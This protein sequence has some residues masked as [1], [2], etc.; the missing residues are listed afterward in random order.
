ME[1]LK[2]SE[3]LKRNKDLQ[4]SFAGTPIEIAVLSNIIV[5]QLKDILEFKLRS[6][7]INVTAN[8]G[9][10]D[11]ILQDCDRFKQSK[12]IIIFWEASNIL[13][14]FH[15]KVEN[16]DQETYL[17]YL[18]KVKEELSFVFNKL[19]KTSL[20]LFN[21]FTS[22]A[23][24]NDFLQESKLSQFCDDLNQFVQ[25]QKKSN[26]QVVDI[27]RIFFDISLKESL[28]LRYYNSS[29]ALYTIRFFKEYSRL[30]HYYLQHLLG[31]SKK[32]LVFD[33]D[34][35]LWDGIIGE[36]GADG[37]LMSSKTAKGKVF[38][39]I[40]YMAQ[41]MSSEGI[42]INLC[43]KNN[44]EDVQNI[45]AKHP[46]IVLSDKNII[47]KKINWNDKVENIKE[48]AK[49]L[50]IGLDSI[51][52]IDDSD[53]EVNNVR[54]RLKDVLVLKVPEKLYDYPSLMRKIS[55][56]FIKSGSSEDKKRTLMYKEEQA[57]KMESSSFENINDYL[58]SLSLEITVSVNK[59]D[60]YVRLAQ[61]TQKTNQFNLTTQRYS[62]TEIL[63]F[64]NSDKVNVFSFSVKDKFGDYGITGMSI[65]KSDNDKADINT[66]LMSCR[67]IG[68]NIEIKFLDYVF[69]FLK[70][71]G[72]NMISSSY[73]KTL[74]NNQVENF[75]ESM[76]MK[77]L[78]TEGNNKFYELNLN[79]YKQTELDYIKIN[80][81][82]R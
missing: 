13:E 76:G 18:N 58:K 50:N 27:N 31:K 70:K 20:I 68:R 59:L 19:E 74:K 64:L 41:K 21:K 82:E 38:E 11:T 8:L 62:E 40:Q 24:T 49:E 14:G 39:E 67:V 73:S 26:V 60:D 63:A 48:I 15:Y 80:D 51:V 36:D 30:A 32:A 16:F 29:K 81:D 54:E 34:N 53:F 66:F 65:V 37:I 57:R 28:D 5:H 35:S 79:A 47:L 25:A 43:S 61:M 17:K 75:Y 9:D 72:I 71:K 33:C 45:L 2:Y 46:D 56:L 78:Q 12:V 6:E 4:K 10:Y 23:F 22:T 7:N 52:F 77:V 42:L 69:S 3:L 55:N 1:D 44:Y